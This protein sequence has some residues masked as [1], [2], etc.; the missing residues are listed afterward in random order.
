[1]RPKSKIVQINLTDEEF[2]FIAREAHKKDITFNAMCNTILREQLDK[3]E[4]KSKR[5]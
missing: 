3:I 1:M 5:V 2:L 4:N